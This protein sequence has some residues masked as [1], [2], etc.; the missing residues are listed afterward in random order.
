MPIAP[1]AKKT[2]SPSPMLEPTCTVRRAY[3]CHLSFALWARH[4]LAGI[5]RG[6]YHAIDPRRTRQHNSSSGSAQ[7]RFHGE[8]LTTSS[9]PRRL[10]C[11]VTGM[12][13]GINV[14]DAAPLR[15][16][17]VVLLSGDSD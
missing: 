6:L 2:A 17:Q 7:P 5:I 10:R 1:L 14:L 3:G 16:D 12:Y 11:E 8:E 15:V 9:V 13:I 4:A